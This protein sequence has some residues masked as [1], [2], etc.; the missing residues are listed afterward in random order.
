MQAVA[1]S[2]R[3][4]S[5]CVHH[6]HLYRLSGSVQH[7]RLVRHKWIPADYLPA[8]P[9]P[10][11][12]PEAHNGHFPSRTHNC[13]VLRAQDADTDVILVGWLLPERKVGKSLSF[14][15]LKDQYGETQLAVHARGVLNVMREVPVESAVLVKGRVKIRP[16]KNKM[17]DQPTGEIEVAVESLT[18]MN[19]ADRKLP[20]YPSD[21]YNLPKEELRM[22]YRY[23]DL[24]RS[25]L[26]SNLQK[27]SKVAHIVRTILHERDFTEV[28]TPILLKSTP[29]GARE[30]LV[31]TRVSSNPPQVFT[32]EGSGPASDSG[33]AAIQ[34]QFY[35]LPQSP[36]Q[37]KQLLVVSGAV[38][39]YYQ[40]ARCFR[41]E[42][43]RKDRQPE[44]TQV[45]LEMAWVDWGEPQVTPEVQTTS[46]EATVEQSGIEQAEDTWRIGGRNVRDVV[47]T[48]IRNIWS[49]VEGIELPPQFRVMTYHEAMKRYGSDKPD[50]RFGLEIFRV[51]SHLNRDMRNTLREKREILE[52]LVLPAVP[53]GTAYASELLKLVD[54]E[55][56]IEHIEVAASE[57]TSW[58]ARS[59]VVQEL[60]SSTG[61]STDVLDRD[62]TSVMGLEKGGSV[63]LAKR[64]RK[65]EGGSTAL[66]RLRLEAAK[67]AQKYG[68]L[69]FSNE[70]KFL[71]VTEFPLFTHDED[72]EFLAK[73][74][75]SSSHHPFTAPML[76]DLEKL[77]KPDKI[78]EVRGQHYDLVLNGVEIGGGSVRVHDAKMQEYVFREILQLGEQEIASFEHL[79]QALRSG[80]PPHGGFAFGFDRLVAILCKT[81]SIRDVIAFPKT[82]DG[83]DLLF[84]SPSPAD[85]SVLA[86]YGIR[87]Q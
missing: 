42:D 40:L 13:G 69:T 6:A 18:L 47:E 57:G 73:G 48:V 33:S 82:K 63:W 5:S 34:P 28:E 54:A 83:T 26:T 9:L 12:Q 55:S 38:D 4:L 62:I 29:E 21:P 20:F 24:R 27:R 14:F 10:G 22:Q 58:L 15:T 56:K 11:K 74:R 72:K 66:G 87:P 52:A 65:T 31:P 37:P 7:H 46:L 50:L 67:I 77:Y 78:H 86:Q 80:A 36:Q 17:P 41:D 1:R 44:F 23:L 85:M 30:F 43:G 75:W 49:Q 61:T 32:S 70:P 3:R 39:R 79:L 53:P 71:W 59:R 2:F 76:D 81:E 35:A 16:E 51:S 25:A 45:D 84:K 19:P 8:D 68:A 64:P 60:L